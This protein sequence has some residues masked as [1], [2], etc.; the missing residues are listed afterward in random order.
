MCPSQTLTRVCVCSGARSSR[1]RQ[2][3]DVGV[4]VGGREMVWERCV[5]VVVE[6][7]SDACKPLGREPRRAV[8]TVTKA[9]RLSQTALGA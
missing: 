7:K 2:R 4:C 1:R 6:T 9:W 8:A 3:G 5:C